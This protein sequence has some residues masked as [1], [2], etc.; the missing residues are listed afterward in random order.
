MKHALSLLMA[1][2]MAAVVVAQTSQAQPAPDVLLKA[3]MQKEQIDNDLP[4]AIAAYKALVEKFPKSPQAA[5]ALLQLAGVYALRNDPVGEREALERVLRE[6]PNS[7]APAEAARARLG[8]DAGVKET[9]FEPTGRADGMLGNGRVSPDGRY[10]SFADQARRELGG[11]GSLATWD[12]AT[13]ATTIVNRVSNRTPW[14]DGIAEDSVWSPHGDELAYRWQVS[15]TN[16]RELRIVSVARGTHRTILVPSARVLPTP[17]AWSPD[18]KSILATLAARAGEGTVGRV[19]LVILSVDNGTLTT[20]K[21]FDG[22]TPNGGTFSPDGRYVAFDFQPERTATARD[23]AAIEVATGRETSIVA[24]RSAHDVL[25]GWLPSGHILYSSD[26]DGSVDAWAVQIRSGA[27]GRPFVVKR[28]VGRIAPQG[29]TRD[30]RVMIWKWIEYREIF[31]AELNPETGKAALP[32]AVLG[33]PQPSVKRGEPNWSPDGSRIAFVQSAPGVAESVVV[34][35]VATGELRSYPVPVR[36]LDW[37]LWS[38]DGR[39]FLF[40]GTG[41]DNVQRMFRLELATGRVEPASDPKRIIIGMSADATQ[42]YEIGGGKGFTRRN[43]TD[44]SSE[45]LGAGAPG[46]S[47]SPDLK[48]LAYIGLGIRD[49]RS[50]NIRPVNGGPEQVL[51]SNI[52]P[53]YPRITWSRDS[54]HIIFNNVA[55]GLQR[56]SIDGGPPVSLGIKDLGWV[57]EKSMNADGRRLAFGVTRNR[58]ELWMWDNVVPNGGRR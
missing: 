15:A 9:K 41:E 8:A 1:V 30:G 24:D 52:N 44:G 38:P 51:V 20:L 55:L 53:G 50:I 35:V 36:N 54:R 56:V 10:V 5:R 49:Q 19:Q 11:T 57:T 48:W 34:Q 29:V 27:A 26:H 7:G 46:A 25:L 28:D 13:G 12:T 43:L 32:P 40:D 47:L 4:G 16:E 14:A 37:T 21:E 18:G 31:V 3:A 17:L 33:R 23:V 42:V 2:T 39:A 58:T 45:V 6:H 22:S